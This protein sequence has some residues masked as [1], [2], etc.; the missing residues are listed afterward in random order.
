V[1]EELAFCSAMLAFCSAMLASERLKK[2]I[3]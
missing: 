1:A 3:R 2:K